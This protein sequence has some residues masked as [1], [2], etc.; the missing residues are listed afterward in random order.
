MSEPEYEYHSMMA[1]TWDLF[2]GDTSNWDDR[3]FFLD[4][5]RESGEP[6]LDVGCG[7]G[8]LLLDYLSKGMDIDG[9]D[10]SPDML[11]IC[12]QKAKTMNLTPSLFESTME[13]MSLPRHYQTIVVP[14]STF[15][16]I[17]DPLLAKEAMLRLFAH[18]LPGGTLAMPFML[19]WKRGEPLESPWRLMGEKFR[20][21]DG[22]TIQ[23]WSFSRY[24]PETQ[25]EHTEDRY[26]VVKDG[27]TISKE[28]HAR[29]P[30]TREYSQPQAQDLYIEAGFV[31]IFIYKGFTRLAASAEDEIFVITG[32]R[33]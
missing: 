32:K 1:Q 10:N 17:L 31:D 19:V 13:T 8:R 12:R 23:R 29:S 22:A 26:D 11:S 16:L 28:Y 14:S 27:I 2:R 21:E 15:Q 33:P 3:Y 24:D 9:L 7:T 18:L 25:L 5:I 30:A 4:L 6:A 20:L